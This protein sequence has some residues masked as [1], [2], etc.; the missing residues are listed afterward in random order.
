M[1]AQHFFLSCKENILDKT[2]IAVDRCVQYLFCF[3]STQRRKE[4]RIRLVGLHVLIMLLLSTYAL[5]AESNL[6][7]MR[8]TYDSGLDEIV[9]G[10]GMKLQDLGQTYLKALS[11]LENR[12]ADQGNLDDVLKVKQE[13]TRF[14]KHKRIPFK[15]SGEILPALRNI[16]I[17]YSRSSRN[18]KQ[19][20]QKRTGYC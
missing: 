6:A 17:A 8:A 20:K 12:L 16:Q 18:W 4:M 7:T 10:H 3:L 19:T 9:L 5:F 11:D 15:T 1:F 2:S 13:A 14:K